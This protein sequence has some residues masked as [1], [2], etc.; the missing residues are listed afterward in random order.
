MAELRKP[1]RSNDESLSQASVIVVRVVPRS[2]RIAIEREGP[3][4]YKVRLTSPPVDGAANSQ[5]LKVLSERLDLP[6]RWIQLL[7]GETARIKRIKIEGL[8]LEQ[9]AERLTNS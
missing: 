3:S 8:D 1:A 4:D 5:L 6:S 2:S 7:S 9:I